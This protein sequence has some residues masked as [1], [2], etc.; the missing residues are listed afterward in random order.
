M[1]KIGLSTN[2]KHINEELFKAYKSAGISVMEI[3]V[4]YEALSSLD[5]SQL[6]LLSK[7]YD[8]K[9]WSFHLPFMPFDIIDIASIDSSIRQ[10]TVKLCAEYIKKASYIG[11]NKFVIHPSGEP[12][13]D[14][15]RNEMTKYSKDSLDKL[16]EIAYKEGS[17]IAV[18]NLARTCL[19]RNS[20]EMLE[21]IAANDKL[22]VCFDT[23]HLLTENIVAFIQK[24]G[25]RIVTIHVSDCDFINERHWLPGEGKIDW[26]ALLKA[27]R[28]A[29]YKGPW[30]YEIAFKCPN[31]II[32][33][34][35]LT[36]ADFYRNAMELFSAAPF[37]ILSEHKENLGMWG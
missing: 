23:N 9:L 36:C 22:R 19:G 16:S 18:E 33:N 11:I 30:L 2:R 15:E 24:L 37:T 26:Q 4:P 8:V 35:D 14:S 27:L 34:R 5:F 25:D 10:N 28:E 1:Y 3:S 31:T 7:K 12:V 21:L 6:H 17:M 13:K 32:R 20:S 29:D